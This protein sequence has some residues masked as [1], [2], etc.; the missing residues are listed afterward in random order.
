[1]Y[2]TKVLITTYALTKNWKW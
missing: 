1:L 2:K